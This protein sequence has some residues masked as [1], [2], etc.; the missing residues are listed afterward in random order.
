[1]TFGTESFEPLGFINLHLPQAGLVYFVLILSQ[2]SFLVVFIF[3]DLVVCFTPLK[4][5][6]AL[7]VTCEYAL[8]LLH[9]G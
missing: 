2:R 5:T 4:A 9:D 8:K 3:L 1:M 6:R 7:C